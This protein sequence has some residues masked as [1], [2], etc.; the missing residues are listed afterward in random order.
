MKFPYPYPQKGNV[1]MQRL[2]YPT[3]T[4]LSNKITRNRIVL[5]FKDSPRKTIRTATST[6]CNNV[7]G[8]STA[9]A[10]KSIG[11]PDMEGLFSLE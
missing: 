9:H 5:S 4:V 1:L 11:S 3:E 8:R 6:V 7:Q 2:S 10:V